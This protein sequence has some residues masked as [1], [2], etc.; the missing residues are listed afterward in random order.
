MS[1][2]WV[3]L[4]DDPQVIVPI[5]DEVA[6]DLGRRAAGRIEARRLHA[7]ERD[8]A[9]VGLRLAEP[10]AEGI[11]TPAAGGRFAPGR[12]FLLELRL[13]AKGRQ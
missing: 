1:Q 12:H 11:L 10:G 2:I 8:G 7:A 6:M 9:V 13:E 5:T 4:W 3:R